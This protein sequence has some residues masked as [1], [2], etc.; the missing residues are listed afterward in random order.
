MDCS[1]SDAAPTHLNPLR[2]R[3]AAGRVLTSVMITMPSVAAAQLWARSGLDM[4]TLD[5]EH[6]PI[7]IESVHAMIAATTGGPGVPV[8]R[9]PWNVP[10]LVKPVLDAGAMG[11]FFPL[12]NSADEARAAV[13]AV[14]YPPAGDRGWGA[15]YAPPRWAT[16]L[17]D[18][19]AQA[20]RA[21]LAMPCIEHPDAV[22][23]I[24]EIVAVPG[25][26]L[27][28]IA[29]GDLALGMGRGN[30]RDHPAV[31]E[32][33]AHVEQRVL[34]SGVPLGGVAPTRATALAMI[35]RGYQCLHLAF[36]WLVIQQA[37]TALTEGLAL[38]R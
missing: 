24:D 3:L 9:V 37:A 10:W 25:I 35:D 18:Y 29:P 5:M 21:V 32:A 23:R 16:S 31:R 2:A 33:I 6:S 26:D 1:M 15:F 22:A 8:V 12:I 7:G 13:R 36:D 11:I 4:I 27:I 30:Q 19:M 28:F 14:R 34:A 20:D 38:N 17:P